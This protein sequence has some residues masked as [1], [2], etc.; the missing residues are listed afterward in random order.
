GDNEA[1]AG[2]YAVQIFSGPVQG[3][4]GGNAGGIPQESGR[5]SGGTAPAVNGDEIR[6]PKDTESQIRLNMACGDLDSHRPSAGGHF[7]LA[8]QGF[9]IFLCLYAG[10]AGRGDNILTHGAVPEPADFRG[11]F[12]RRQVSAHAGL[13]ALADLNLNGVRPLKIFRS[14]AVEIAYILKNVFS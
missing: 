6:F 8:D 4:D 11:D 13:S 9:Q 2:V 7:Q 1:D 5:G 3:V 10:K 12:F 14:D